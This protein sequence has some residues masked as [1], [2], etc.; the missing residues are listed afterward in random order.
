M[1]ALA[2]ILDIERGKRDAVSA[3]RQ[4]NGSKQGPPPDDY[5]HSDEDAPSAVAKLPKE[6]PTADDPLRGL[7]HLSVVALLGREKLLELAAR[8]V[9]YIFQ[10]IAVAGTIILIAGPP[11]EGKTTLLFLILAG[12]LN[13]GDPIQLLGRRLDPAPKGKWVVVIEGEHS[14]A[15]TSR[16]LV[17]S[18][19]LLGLDDAALD[20]VIVVARK[21]VRLGSPEWADIGH[22]VAAG[23]VS[24]IALDTVARVAP[25]DADNERDQVAIFDAVAR[26]IDLA[27]TDADKP[28]VWAVAHTRKNNT[29][30]GLEDVS[31]SAQRTG[32]ADSVLLIKGEKVEGRTVSTKVTFGKLRED[33]DEYPMP[34]TFSIRDGAVHVS[35][36]AEVPDDRP[37]E[38]RIVE[39]LHRGPK[40]QNGLSHELKR[41]YQ[42]LNEPIKNLFSARTITTDYIKIRGKDTKVLK[43]RTDG[44]GAA[45]KR[46]EWDRGWTNDDGGAS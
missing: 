24:D 2:E 11:A 30:G 26:T 1:I 5:V 35:D 8:P 41:S 4:K 28:T 13:V 6:R 29:S 17:K 21:A 42:D 32:Q 3:A 16:K 44:A 27:P 7:Q 43:L 15:S 38:T 9:D 46:D 33:P 19:R 20:R 39:V 45:P 23:L 36:A 25:A 37:L 31:G 10:D 12:R 22:L 14:E 18:L 34:V 40:S